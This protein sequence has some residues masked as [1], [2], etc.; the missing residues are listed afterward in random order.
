MGIT[1]NNCVGTPWASLDP[2]KAMSEQRLWE[3]TRPGASGG[4]GRDS[5]GCR[6]GPRAQGKPTQPGSAVDARRECLL[7]LLPSAWGLRIKIRSVMHERHYISFA[8][9]IFV[10]T[11]PTHR[12]SQ[13]MQNCHHPREQSPLPGLRSCFAF[14]LTDVGCGFSIGT[15]LRV[16]HELSNWTKDCA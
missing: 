11:K 5:E 12:C 4:C 6:E 2:T 1:E 8:H 15:Y 16:V 14:C 10:H 3:G 7:K 13:C 9:L